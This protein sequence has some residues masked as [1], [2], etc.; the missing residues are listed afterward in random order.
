M[1]RSVRGIQDALVG[2]LPGLGEQLGGRALGVAQAGVAA[3]LLGDLVHLLAGLQE[4]L[5]VAAVEVAQVHRDQSS[6]RVEYV[7]RGGVEPVGE[8]DRVGEHDRQPRPSGPGQAGHPGGVRRG[9]RPGAGQPVGDH[10]DDQLAGTD[11]VEPA[12]QDLA[13]EVVTPQRGRATQLGGR[14]EQHPDVPG[15]GRIRRRA[16]R[17]APACTPGCRARRRRGSPRPAGTPPPTPPGRWPGRSPGAAAGPGRHRRGPGCVGDLRWWRSERQRAS[18]NTRS[19]GQVDA[20]DRADRPSPSRPWRTG[21]RRRCRRGRSARGRPSPARRRA[22]R[23]RGG[24]R[25]RTAGSSRR[26]R[27]GGRTGRTTRSSP[28]GHAEREVLG[29]PERGLHQREEPVG[30]THQVVGLPLGDRPP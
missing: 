1:P 10:L 19:E 29:Q 23:G 22:R 17:P 25:R 11:Q 24:A 21:P 13:T 9:T 18:G 3:D 14:P 15:M 7:G 8:P 2:D 20:E 12:L 16:R 30:V 5:G 26:R 4:A 27:G 28:S 6:G